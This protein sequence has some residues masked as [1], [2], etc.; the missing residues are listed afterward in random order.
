MSTRA[1]CTS[2]K[3][4]LLGYGRLFFFF[5]PVVNLHHAKLLVGNAQNAHM[6]TGWQV[7][8]YT[9]YVNFGIFVAGAMAQVGTK[10]KHG[11]AIFHHLLPEFCIVFPVLLGFGGQIEKYHDPHNTVFVQSHVYEGSSGYSIFLSVP[12]K[13]LASEAVVR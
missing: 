13:H 12:S 5:L 1:F 3:F 11:K 10:L 7:F 4:K 2:K 6:P 9:L 8:L